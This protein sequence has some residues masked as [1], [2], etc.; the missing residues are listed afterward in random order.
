MKDGMMHMVKE[1]KL[2][3]AAGKTVVLKRGGLHIMFI[4]PK[5]VHKNGDKIEVTFKLSNKQNQKV[6][7]PVKKA[8]MTMDHSKHKHMNH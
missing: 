5:K 3:V 2:P 6:V 8:A 1:D 7:F 4:K